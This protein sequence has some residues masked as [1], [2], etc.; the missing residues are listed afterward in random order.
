M[1]LSFRPCRRGGASA[2]TPVPCRVPRAPHPA[3]P[4][5]IAMPLPPNTPLDPPPG[6]SGQLG[7]WLPWLCA[8]AFFLLPIGGC[9]AAA[10]LRRPGASTREAAVAAPLPGPAAPAMTGVTMVPPRR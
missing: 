1:E 7:I 3:S 9:G 4:V 6:R 5:S 8:P 2:T 10:A